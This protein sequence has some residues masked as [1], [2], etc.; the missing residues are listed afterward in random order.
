MENYKINSQWCLWFHSLN[1][2]K[3]TKGSY[4][5]LFN[6]NNLFDYHFL[7][8]TFEKQHLQNGMFFVMRDDIFPTWEDPEN[9][10]GGCIS[11]KVDSDNILDS[12]NKLLL[13]LISENIVVNLDLFS[14]INGISIAPKKE[15]NIIKIWI[16]N[17]KLNYKNLV[18]DINPYFEIEKCLYKKH[19]LEY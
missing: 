5:N 3:W 4:E 7:K 2:D 9:R 1:N 6:I 16:K 18:K 17:D 12:W 15:F 8:N 10:L 11:Y 13:N 14:E 19:E